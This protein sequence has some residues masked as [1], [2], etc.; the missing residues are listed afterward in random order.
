MEFKFI[1][2]PGYLG[3]K[4][5]EII[6]LWDKEY[7]K[8]NWRLMWQWGSVII[9][10][11]DAIQIYEDGYYEFL[12][13]EKNILYWLINNYKDI[14]DTA[15]SNIN[16]GLDY[17]IQETSNT[18]LHDI[19]IRRVILRLGKEF[20]G[21]KIMRVRWKDSEGFKLSPGVVPFHLPKMIC[22]EEL[23]DYTGNGIWWDENS[24]ED[25]YQR[26]K[27]LQVKH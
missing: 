3:K 15:E 1:E 9:P 5:D 20:H 6:E 8:D 22:K 17:E 19:S 21:E 18:H 13:K 7:G 24:I 23:K 25:F 14:Y 11:K 4:R 2:R 26:N 16:S 12:G 10:R 27:L